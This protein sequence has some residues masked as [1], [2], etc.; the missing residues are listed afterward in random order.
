L[1]L[2]GRTIA[3]LARDLSLGIVTS[4]ALVAESLASIA[5]DGSAFTRVYEAEARVTARESDAARARGAVRSPLEGIPVS[6]KDLFDVRGEP[7]PAGSKLL[8]DAPAAADDAPV[9]TRLRAS[10]AI[11][12]GRTHMSEFAFS[13]LGTNPHLSRLANPCDAERVPGGSSSGAAVSVARGQVAMG[14]GTDTGGSTRIPAAFCGVVGFKPTQRRVTRAGAFPLAESLDSIGP[15]ANAVACCAI[16]DRIVADT[17]PDSCPPVAV[18][19]LKLAVPTD[20]VLEDID[21]A[22]N[23]AFNRALAALERA[24]PSIRPIPFPEFTRVRELSANGT[25]AN[26]EAFAIHAR[27]SG[28]QFGDYDPNVRARLEIGRRM[29]RPQYETLL[30][31]RTAL[32]ADADRRSAGYDA[33]IMPTMATPAPRFADVEAPA[34]WSSA[35]AL[36]LRNTSL[37]NFFDRCAISLPMHLPG[38]LPAGLM[39]VGATGGD[40]RLLAIA[41]AVEGCLRGSG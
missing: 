39:L 33:L 18:K 30:L 41:E 32:I 28:G 9:I 29:T 4:E 11:I 27:L 31:A 40:A 3:E 26:A 1:A 37:A 15:I 20:A 36:S 6:I 38:E 35:N 2:A 19:T 21:P 22:V 25:I 8:R 12:V 24:G 14:L 10:G 5:R 17:A 7:T 23:D 34:A 13:G 16:V